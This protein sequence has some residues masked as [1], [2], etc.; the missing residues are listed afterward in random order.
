M[1]LENKV[2]YTLVVVE[3]LRDTFKVF[4]EGMTSLW[5]ELSAVR[6][7]TDATFDEVGRIRIELN[8]VSMRLDSVENRLGGIE[9]RIGVLERNSNLIKDEIKIIKT[10]I[11]EIKR[12]LTA[13]ADMK[14][15]MLFEARVARIEKKFV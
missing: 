9:N 8:Q 13:K 10:D 3:E 2:D 5:Q 6:A 14:Y 11:A 15:I 12:T 7:K 4:G 1:T